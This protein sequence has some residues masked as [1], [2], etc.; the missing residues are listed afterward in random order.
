MR[1]RP[2]SSTRVGLAEV[3]VAAGICRVGRLQV[4]V[5]SGCSRQSTA[6]QPKGAVAAQADMEQQRAEAARG[7]RL[8]VGLREP[9]TRA[10]VVVLALVPVLLHKQVALVS[11]SSRYRE[12]RTM[13]HY[14]EIDNQNKVIRVLVVA[15][16]VTHATPDG[17]EDEA[18][19]ATFL[20]DLLGGTWVQT[21]YNG[22][23][24]ARYAGP[25]FT[26]DRE[27]DEF[28]PPGWSLVDGVW[29]TP[30]VEPLP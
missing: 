25:G 30:P 13:A 28:V 18:L 14:A 22:N 20:R 29:T 16:E 6:R 24:R 12:A 26:F 3:L 9:Q 23:K 17:S 19:G 27:R 21:S 5:A 11:S 15:N 7:A 2:V 1:V 10:G 8:A 4:K